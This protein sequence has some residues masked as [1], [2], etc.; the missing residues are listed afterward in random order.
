MKI[1]KTYLLSYF[2][3]IF[4][5]SNSEMQGS[6]EN[7][8][9]QSSNSDSD[10]S[11]TTSSS[12]DIPETIDGMI[13]LSG[14][15]VTVGSN[16]KEFKSN[17]KPAMQVILDYDFFMDIHEVT[18]GDY[19]K[20]AKETSLK[21]FPCDSDSLPITDVTY[22]DAILFANAKS[23]SEK[24]DTVYTYTKATYDTEGHCTDLEG[25]MFHPEAAGYRLPT[26]AEWIFAATRDWDT[27]KSWNNGNSDY[28]AHDVCSK[29]TDSTGFCDMV[30]NVMEWVNDWLG[31]F[32]DTTITNY[33]GAPDGG[34]KGER[35]VKGG[36]Y[37]ST[38]KELN[39]YSRGDVY[40]VTSATRAEYVGFR[41]ALGSIPD[42]LW[43]GNDGKTQTGIVSPLA[44]GEAIKGL[45]GTYNVKLAFRNDVSGNI[46]YIDYQNGAPIVNEISDSIDAYH[47]DI[48]PDGNYVAFCTG[49]EGISKKSVLYVR[50]LDKDDSNVAQLKVESAAIPRWRV[51][52]NGDT[53]IVYVT[54]AG[55]NKDETTFLSASTWQVT[56][57]NGKFGTPQKLFDGAFHGGISEDN[58]LAVTG[59]RLLRARIAKS[60]SSL[61]QNAKNTVWYDNAQACNASLAMDKSKRTAFL[62]F[63][64]KPGVE[65]VG[66]DYSTH[67]RIFIA[68]SVG[69]L[70]QSIK[71]PAGYTFDH[72]EWATDG[73]N[74]NI[75]ATLTNANGAHTKIVLVNPKD[76]STTE[77]VEG[78]E[79]WH[80][81][82]WIKKIEADPDTVPDIGFKLDP[83]SAGL[84]YVSSGNWRHI[85]Y[86]YKMQLLWKYR[87]SINVIFLGSS[88]AFYALNPDFIE[89]PYFAVN[90]ANS[91][92]TLQG[93]FSLFKNYLLPH[94]KNLK[95]VVLGTDL[96]RLL[97]LEDFFEVEALTIP[98][99]AYDRSHN[100]WVDDFPK[101]LVTLTEK[102]PVGSA[103]LKNT[104]L[105]HNGFYPEECNGW[106]IEN[107]E[108]K[109]D[110]NWHKKRPAPFDQN[111]ETLKEFPR[112]AQERGIR[113]I[114][115]EIPLNPAYKNTG[116]YGNNGILRSEAPALIQQIQ[117]ISETYPN[118]I[119][120]NE[121]NFGDHDYTSEMALDDGHL[122][123]VGAEQLTKRVFTLIKKLDAESEP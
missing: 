78:D 29:G 17:E 107:P 77:L 31:L 47:P 34:E 93:A 9:P 103:T 39:P 13:R 69:K 111:M 100:Y 117:D 91:G 80:P 1:R 114:G 18:C 46:A 72:T 119:F 113:V 95:Y 65:F 7:S 44:G 51:L 35:I 3:L 30:G 89:P 67:E 42:A 71:A 19:D 106:S 59:A 37:A 115:I 54:N 73:I 62:D 79:L 99:Y 109:Q 41:L 105:A 74:S 27:D 118:F 68:D 40:T 14:G 97:Y 58:T 122:C 45:T 25:L 75:V 61:T 123:P 20:V 23:L 32:R 104:L 12:A 92:N 28:S 43:M 64:G 4:A 70:V 76:S 57:K 98:G 33:L 24:R 55:N 94:L 86:R 21:R 112:L 101:E 88:R 121:N 83:D 60:G 116:A 11:E 53:A 52:E 15:K 10:I 108:L 85:N 110:S 26:E 36:Y 96:D 120:M 82:L 16:D 84:Y 6:E 50:K 56:F 63:V 66:K 5:C 2:L 49:L 102:G 48:S 38:L 8:A 87:D 90:F 22:L 81:A